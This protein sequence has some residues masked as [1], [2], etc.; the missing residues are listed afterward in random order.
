MAT[1]SLDGYLAPNV[2]AG[3]NREAWY[4]LVCS[5]PMLK[6]AAQFCVSSSYMAWIC[7]LLNAPRHERG[8]PRTSRHA[9]STVS[10]CA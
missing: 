9:V 8:Y 5:E 2:D 6:M 1:V 10:M 4:E 7:T 3:L